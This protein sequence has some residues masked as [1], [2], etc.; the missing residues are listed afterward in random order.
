MARHAGRVIGVE[1]VPQA[2]ANAKSNARLNGLDNARFLC[3]EAEK[4]L[5]DFYNGK[6]VELLTA[7]GY[8]ADKDGR[9]YAD[10]TSPDVI[11][12]DPPRKGCDKIALDTMISMSPS[13]IVYVSCDSATLARDI[14]YLE[15]AGYHLKKY[16]VCDQF[17]HTTH[18]EV[19]CIL[20]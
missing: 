16:T 6:A 20:S 12:V 17:G 14:K 5:P 18:T 2:I 8:D 13:R 15:E 11:V 3:G 19:V 4:V 7:E 9:T 10:M 1:V